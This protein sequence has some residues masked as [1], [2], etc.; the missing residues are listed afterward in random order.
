MRPLPAC[1]LAFTLWVAGA[2]TAAPGSHL[3]ADPRTA[4]AGLSGTLSDFGLPAFNGQVVAFSA[5]RGT[6]AGIYAGYF[7]G[8]PEVHKVVELSDPTPDGNT[9][10]GIAGPAAASASG[11]QA[12]AFW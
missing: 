12:V 11:G 1:Y 10:I 8:S 7:S 9:Y 6:M 5:K 2:A 3:V 4:I